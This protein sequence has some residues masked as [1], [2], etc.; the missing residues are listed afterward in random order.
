MTRTSLPRVTG[1]L[2]VSGVIATW[3]CQRE[4]PTSIAPFAPSAFSIAIAEHDSEPDPRIPPVC[5][6]YTATI[7][8]NM[9]AEMIP[10]G[11][12]IKPYVPDVRP[13]AEGVVALE[14]EGDGGGWGYRIVGTSGNDVI[15]GSPKKDRIFGQNGDDVICADPPQHSDV[16]EGELTIGAIDDACDGGGGSPGHGG[17]GPDRIWG[18]Y[19][20]DIIY[21][22]GGPDT[23]LAGHGNDVVYGGGGP[24]VIYGEAGNDEL[25]GGPGPDWLYGGFDRDKLYGEESNDWLFGEGGVDWLFGG[26]GR[27]MLDGGSGDNHLDE[28]DQE[29]E[30]GD[31]CGGHT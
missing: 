9:P 28:G 21:G 12:T 10:K 27:D 5:H 15:V 20:N 22:G 18:G 17:G 8:W 26:S 7:W 30:P 4:L 6:G 24:D 19:G 31:G 2:L 1:L 13:S 14:D 25:H 3:G 11:A 29:D 23:I 16:P